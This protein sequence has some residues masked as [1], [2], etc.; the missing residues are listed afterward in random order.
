MF[1]TC[2]LSCLTS[3]WANYSYVYY[4][5]KNSL[6]TIMT[7]SIVYCDVYCYANGALKSC[8]WFQ[9]GL[10]VLQKLILLYK[11]LAVVDWYISFGGLQEQ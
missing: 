9:E 6:T 1:I 8:L 11:G 3:S 4:C 2:L 5:A 7:N 10:G